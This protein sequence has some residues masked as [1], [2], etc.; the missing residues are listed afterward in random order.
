MVPG[1][2]KGS[3]R[4]SILT[5]KISRGKKGIKVIGLKLGIDLKRIQTFIK[6]LQHKK[7]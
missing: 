4:I 3:L 2:K 5:E 6:E 1:K 7:L